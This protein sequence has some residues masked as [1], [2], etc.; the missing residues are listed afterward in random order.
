M[1]FVI[2]NLLM[3][4]FSQ[5]EF[6][7][8]MEEAGDLS[9]FSV[10]QQESGQKGAVLDNA[11]DI[12]VCANILITKEYCMFR[13]VYHFLANHVPPES[14]CHRRSYVTC[15]S[16]LLCWKVIVFSTRNLFGIIV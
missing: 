3:D 14:V 11:T 4:Y 5:E 6:R 1:I 12:K 2:T 8:Q 7:K 13:H 15:D 16:K 10:S 9:Q